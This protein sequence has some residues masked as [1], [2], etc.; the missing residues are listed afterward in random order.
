M[1]IPLYLHESFL[2][3]LHGMKLHE[4]PADWTALR[5]RSRLSAL[6]RIRRGEA[7]VLLV[8][9][10]LFLFGCA[11]MS[12]EDKL[13]RAS[14][15]Y[16]LGVSY[17]NENNIQPAFVEFQKALEYNPDDKET[18]NAI[19][20]I[21]LLKLEDYPKAITHFQRALKEDRNYAEAWN[22]LGSAYEKMGRYPDAVEAYKTALTN[23][24]YK[25]VEKAFYNLGRVYYRMRKFSDA[26]D[27]YK[28]SIKRFS[29]FYPP[30]Y[31]MALCYNAL[32]RYGDAATALRKAIE[33]DP[34]YKGD[35]EKAIREMKERKLLVKAEE[36]KDIEDLIE[37][38][39]Y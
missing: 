39:N 16:Q 2:I 7:G 4:Q 14:A 15:H 22:N 13:Q 5:C 18:L 35:K 33:L 11:S 34:A 31:G 3:I 29:D 10:L 6:R 28:E 1:K 9:A 38:M 8:C 27:A 19:G 25:S 36:E 17:L 37:I 32:G 23:P 21:Y 26:V 30:Y 20:I 12:G 24:F